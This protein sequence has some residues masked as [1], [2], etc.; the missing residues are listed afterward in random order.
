MRREF[1][2][3]AKVLDI[4]KIGVGGR[5]CIDVRG[6]WV[7]E[8]LNG[9]RA[10]WDGGVTRGMPCHSIGWANDIREGAGDVSTGLWSRLGK[11]IKAPDWWID[12]LPVGVNLDG[13]LWCE[14]MS[15]E[16]ILSI[17]KS[18]VT[19]KDWS[20]ISYLVFDSPGKGFYVSGEVVF[21]ASGRKNVDFNKMEGVLHGV[22]GGMTDGLYVRRNRLVTSL[23]GSD[24]SNCR[25]LNGITL[26]LL[27][28]E[29]AAMELRSYWESIMGDGSR[30]LLPE[31]LMV[32]LRE[33]IWSPK[34]VG[35]LLKYKHILVGTGVVV[36][37][38]SGRA[39]KTGNMLG[40]IG[41]IE[42]R[43]VELDGG[44][45]PVNV[46]FELGTGLSMAD[47]AILDPEYRQWGW[48]NP[49]E[50]LPPG[51]CHHKFGLGERIEFEYCS[52]TDKGVPVSGRVKK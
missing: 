31:G 45:E 1:L 47:R 4:E 20:D 7:S 46:V 43:V 5:G 17:V 51:F 21:G 35:T 13:E 33:D 29:K 32:R 2:Q 6:A 36:G 16:H 39:G 49:G 44:G 34:R 11:R 52:L 50:R 48:E 24:A 10:Y 15:L 23:G 8:K 18:D 28:I 30:S 41:A 22:S 38:V 9:M 3:L 12:Q 40:S 19:A 42:V 14:G 27:D 25:L 26:D 37:Y